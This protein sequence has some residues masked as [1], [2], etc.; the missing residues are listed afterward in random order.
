MNSQ[1]TSTIYN[2][3]GIITHFNIEGVDFDVTPFGSGHIND[4]F[5]VK[6]KTGSYRTYLLQKINHFVFKNI[7]G[8]M[9]NMV[10]VVNHLKEKI[11]QKPDGNP[12]KE[13]L[14]LVP[15]NNGDRKST[16]LNSSHGGISRM[17]S[18]A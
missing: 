11:A 5:L 13:V 9:N 2:F 8:L 3:A 1:S 17:P 14:T 18:S 6:S 10:L 12:E 4:T 15:C 16:R 7:D